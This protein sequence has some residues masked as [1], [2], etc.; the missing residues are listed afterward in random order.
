VTSSAADSLAPTPRRPRGQAVT[1]V[2]TRAENPTPLLRRIWLA[3]PELGGGRPVI[4]GA[5][6]RVYVPEPDDGGR[7]AAGSR[8]VAGRT[9]RSYTVTRWEASTGTCALDFVLH[10]PGPAA[11][12]AAGA[13]A[14]DTVPLTGP[15][16]RFAFPAT[17]TRTLLAGDTTALPAIRELSEAAPTGAH[18]HALVEAPLTER[19]DWT[20]AGTASSAVRLT[21]V[22]PGALLPMVLTGGATPTHWNLSDPDV[23][24]WIGAEAGDVAAMRRHLLAAGLPAA[25]LHATP[26]WRR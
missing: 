17:V 22:D 6:V 23:L 8:E 16:G 4:P 1:A 7:L 13:T 12:W 21:W 15:L 25:S 19:L 14:G 10:G 3:C 18:V 5:W 26:Y 11:A 20:A 9:P 2:V 24:V